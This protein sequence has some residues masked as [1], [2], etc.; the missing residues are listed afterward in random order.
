MGAGTGSPPPSL[1]PRPSLKHEHPAPASLTSKEMGG[2]R[3]YWVKLL[4][5]LMLRLAA[6]PEARQ[7][8]GGG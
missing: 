3:L 1:P 8:F 6:C 5:T 4:L 7:R 2:N